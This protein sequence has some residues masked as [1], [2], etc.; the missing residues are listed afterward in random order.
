MIICKKCLTYSHFS[1]FSLV[2]FGKAIDFIIFAL[3]FN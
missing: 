2:K 3:D 1:R